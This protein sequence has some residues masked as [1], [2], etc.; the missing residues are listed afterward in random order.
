M[1]RSTSPADERASRR[2]RNA[3]AR[4]RRRGPSGA[5]H[6]LAFAHTLEL[7]QKRGDDAATRTPI[8]HS[9]YRHFA[10]IGRPLEVATVVATAVFA[11]GPEGDAASGSPRRRRLFTNGWLPVP[12]V[13]R[14]VAVLAETGVPPA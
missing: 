13:F 1:N 6:G 5:D 10:V 4:D 7:P 2:G 11:V 14:T 8:Q 9:L 3:Q 12:Y